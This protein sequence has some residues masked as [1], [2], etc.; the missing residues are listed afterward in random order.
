MFEEI[1][2]VQRLTLLQAVGEPAPPITAEDDH[3]LDEVVR[4]ALVESSLL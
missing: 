1:V 4:A 3:P 2:A